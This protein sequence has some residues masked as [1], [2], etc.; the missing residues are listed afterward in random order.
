MAR[1]SRE[2]LKRCRATKS[3]E[4]IEELFAGLRF[5]F[6]VGPGLKVDMPTAFIEDFGRYASIVNPE[7]GSERLNAFDALSLLE[8]MCRT[9]ARLCY[10]VIPFWKEVLHNK[11]LLDQEV[12]KLSEIE[13]VCVKILAIELELNLQK[14]RDIQDAF[15]QK[16]TAIAELEQKV[17]SLSIKFLNFANLEMREHERHLQRG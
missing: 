10:L 1:L 8:S 17:A 7:G 12:T 15:F 14:L 2:E 6:L 9:W 3:I 5:E 11:A 4:F 13:D 16:V